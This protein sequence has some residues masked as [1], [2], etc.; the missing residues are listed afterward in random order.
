MWRGLTKWT[1]IIAFGAVGLLGPARSE[2]SAT[3]PRHFAVNSNFDAAGRFVPRAYGFNIADVSS[4]ES[5]DG[6]PD[7]VLGLVWV[8]LCGGANAPF[9]A[10]VDSVIHHPKLFGFYLM[11]DP[12]PSGRWNPRCRGEDLR[13]ES[14]WIHARRASA[15]TFI[16]LMNAGDDAAPAFDPALRPENSH[17]DLFGVAPYPCR[18]KWQE[19]DYAMIGHFVEAARRIGIQD[20][21][22][23]PIYQTFGGGSWSAA[24]G[25]YR[26]PE[27]WELRRI[28]EIWRNLISAPV[29]DYAY[30]WG[31]Q[32]SDASL[33]TS[34][35]LL[36][37][38]AQQNDPNAKLPAKL[39]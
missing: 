39:P 35:P 19:C 27:A 29:F 10:L 7:G 21:S 11:D 3:A 18:R 33:A 20:Q 9:R 17:V 5:L 6:L 26:L 14:D 32:R 25:G 23:V 13:A 28:I 36:E 15:V 38:F 31:T 34:T 4:A 30:S 22:V 2:P 12:D 8:G 24:G 16:A 37:V 1:C